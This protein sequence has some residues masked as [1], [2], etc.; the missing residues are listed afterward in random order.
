MLLVLRMRAQRPEVTE[1][2]ISGYLGY[3]KGHKKKKSKW[4]EKCSDRFKLGSV[5]KV[6]ED[7]V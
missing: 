2:T 3:G 6:G 1:R 7:S 4:T 5:Y